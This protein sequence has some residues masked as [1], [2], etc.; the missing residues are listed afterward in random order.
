MGGWKVA[1]SVCFS[2]VDDAEVEVASETA[3]D[4]WHVGHHRVNLFH[5]RV[6]EGFRKPAGGAEHACVFGWGLPTQ[7]AFEENVAGLD[8]DVH[9]LLL[10]HGLEQVEG[11]SDFPEI[12]AD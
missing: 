1:E 9:E 2:G 6:A 7:V 3:E 5:V 4:D 10:R 8:A 11:S 12:F